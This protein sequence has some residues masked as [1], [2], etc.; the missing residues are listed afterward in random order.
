MNIKELPLDILHKIKSYCNV[1]D[2]LQA[3]DIFG[4]KISQFE[5]SK[6]LLKDKEI[7]GA[8]GAIIRCSAEYTDKRRDLMSFINM[9]I[10][11]DD[12]DFQSY[13]LELYPDEWLHTY[14]F[15]KLFYCE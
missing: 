7:Y 11:P 10:S 6:F 12:I 3:Y 14:L 1:K 9:Y 5:V 2:I 8:Y 4:D 15:S 13:E